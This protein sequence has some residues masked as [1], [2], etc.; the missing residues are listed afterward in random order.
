LI[1]KVSKET[2]ISKRLLIS[3]LLIE[4]LRLM[5]SQRE[6][7][8]KYFQPL[9]ILGSQTQFSLGIYGMKENTAKQIEINLKDKNSP[10]YLGKSFE[11]ILDYKI[12]NSSSSVLLN[13]E[14][15]EVIIRNTNLPT[16]TKILIGNDA[17]RIKRLTNEKDHYYSYL[18]AALYLKQILN[19]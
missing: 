11:N 9:S 15:G 10:Y 4:Q 3:P 2:G 13:S 5:T 18:Y 1:E 7:F 19:Q 14:T 16:S 8:K 6:I 17:E 12:E